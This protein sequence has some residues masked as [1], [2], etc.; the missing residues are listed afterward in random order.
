[1]WP[2]FSVH[3]E[4]ALFVQAGIPPMAALHATTAE[5]AA[6]LGTRTGRVA[7]DHLADLVILDANPLHEIANTQKLSGVVVGGRYL[8]AAERLRILAE[9][10][11]TAAST[12]AEAVAAGCP[13]HG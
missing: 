10:E 4:L 2:G 13:C 1:V 11:H 8:D 3:D 12:P 9:V 7:G 6:F 5:P